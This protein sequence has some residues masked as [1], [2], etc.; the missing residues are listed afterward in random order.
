MIIITKRKRI[1]L[2]IKGGFSIKQLSKNIYIARMYANKK[3]HPIGY[4][5][6]IL[7]IAKND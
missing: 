1:E 3:L 2:A 5:I 6:P 4:Y 7:I